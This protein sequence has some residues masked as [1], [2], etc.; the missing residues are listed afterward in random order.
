VGGNEAVLDAAMTV[1]YRQPSNWIYYDPA[2]IVTELTAAK[3]S[4][5]ALTLIPY[6]RTWAEALQAMELKREVAGTSKIEGAEFTDK[7]LDEAI[8]GKASDEDMTRS[9]RQARAAIKT[10][11]WIERLP[12]DRPIDAALIKEIHR[13]IITGCDDDHCPPGEF[14]GDGQNVTFGRP[15]HRGVDGGNQ[16]TSSVNRLIGALNQ[17][18]R[19]HDQLLQALAIHYHFGAMHPFYDGNGRTARALEALMLQRAHLK[20]TLFIAMSNYYYDEKNAY[21]DALSKVREKN[22]DLTPFLKFALRGIDLQCKRLLREIRA[23]VQKSLFRDVMGKMYGRL[24]SSRKRALAFRQC[25][26]LTKLLDM[27]APIEYRDLFKLVEKDYMPLSAPMRAYVRDLNGLG[28]LR[29]ILITKEEA[30]PRFMVHAR[31]EWATEVTDTEFYKQINKLP[32]AK[33]KLMV[34]H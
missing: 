9:Q 14:R 27:D 22:F 28:N 2:A 17:E 12:H 31:L 23:H 11:R 7:E 21:L 26:I 34:S 25:E 10:Y 6:Q 4:V 15:R 32:A 3:A 24:H 1:Q 8:S 16:C 19:G 18:Y 33:T 5:L 29:A 30:G 13:R 20:D